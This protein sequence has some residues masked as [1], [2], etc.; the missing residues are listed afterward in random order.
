MGKMT[1]VFEYEDGKEPPVS[2]GM[3]FMG[4]K[5]VAAAFRDALEC[6][7]EDFHECSRG[8]LTVEQII[9]DLNESG[10]ISRAL[11]GNMNI[12]TIG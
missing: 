10:P 11:T 8:N 1:F 9:S 3:S 5:I 7:E 6:L 2:A 4:G 12:K